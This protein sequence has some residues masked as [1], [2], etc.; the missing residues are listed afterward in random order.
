VLMEAGADV[1]A[2]SARGARPLHSAAL[3]GCAAT[4]G[5]LPELGVDIHAVDED[6]RTPLH[7]ASSS[8]AVQSLLEAGADLHR[9]DIC[10]ATPLFEADLYGDA[11]AVTAL[12]QAGTCPHASDAFLWIELIINAVEANEEAVAALAAAS[13]ERDRRLTENGHFAHTAVQVAEIAHP[14]D[15]AL[16][17]ALA[18]A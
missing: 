4:M 3:S 6:G 16:R 7:T 1:E 14:A 8:E 17:L 15:E 10:G 9:R 12:V 2:P 18:P 11:S 5:A 13:S